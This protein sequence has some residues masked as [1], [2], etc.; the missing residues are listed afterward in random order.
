MNDTEWRQT[1]G[2]SGSEKLPL[3][4]IIVINW[5]YGAYLP[6]ALQSV[7]SQDYPLLEVITLDNGSSDE[8]PSLF[9]AFAEQHPQVRFIRLDRNLGQLGAAHHIL[10][11]HSVS[12]EFVSFLDSDDFLFPHFI[13]HHV[14]AHS[15]VNNGAGVSTSDTIQVDG[16]GTIV[17]GNM[18]RWWKNPEAKRRGWVDIQLPTA[19]TPPRHLATTLIP[20][21]ERQWCWYPG[22]SIVYRR[23]HVEPLMAAIRAPVPVRFALDTSAA[24]FSHAP[25]GTIML[26]EALSGYRIHGKNSSVT[27]PQLQYFDSGR[28]TFSKLNQRQERWYRKNFRNKIKA[29]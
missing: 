21:T 26:N 3:V 10:T 15:L 1:Y 8:S 5:N 7:A 11:Q 29:S 17:A 23:S 14:R 24:P 27:A 28:A 18:P 9:Q 22:T 16:H 13:S 4:T 25:G 12:G 6:M 19:H 2:V 20:S